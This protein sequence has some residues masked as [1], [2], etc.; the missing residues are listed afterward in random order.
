V[1][2]AFDT[3]FLSILLNRKSAASVKKAV[4]LVDDLVEELDKKNT[5]VIIPAP[6][7]T[8]VMLKAPKSAHE[9]IEKIKEFL[10]F[11]I[12]P[13]DEKSAVELAET[14]RSSIGRKRSKKEVSQMKVTFDRQIVTVAKAHGATTMYSDDKDVRTFSEECGMEAFGF[15]D[16]K[17]S[18]KQEK[19]P[20]DKAE[21]P[22]AGP[23]KVQGSSSGPTEDQTAAEGKSE[24]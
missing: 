8:E 13:F 7:L 20:Y 18:P 16:L 15:A 24:A 6:T 23:A 5:K 21:K 9:Y 22:I 4:E 17:L 11:Q 2:A 19:L 3:P 10:C 14:L 12:K 1:K